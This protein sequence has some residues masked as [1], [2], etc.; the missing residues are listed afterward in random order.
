MAHILLI[1]DA[2]DCQLL[3]KEALAKTATVKFAGTIAEADFAIKNQ[4]FDLILLD[5][6]LP[7]GD[8]MAYFS[9]LSSRAGHAEVPVIFLTS[10]GEAASQVAAFSLGAD[11]YII[12]P[13]RPIEFRARIEA[14]IRRILRS[15]KDETLLIRGDI[16]IDLT[17]QRASVSSTFSGQPGQDLELTGREFKL[18]C[19][20]ARHE[21]T[22][23]SRSQ[24]IAAVWGSAVHVLDRTVDTHVYTL[25]KK[26]G[27][28]SNYIESVVGAG[29]RLTT[30][31]RAE[32]AAA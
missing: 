3:V 25:R 30:T 5:L 14:R 4:K 15:Q 27:A 9:A 17:T 28:H 2:K 8:G 10:Q 13:I 26:L 19:H 6:S 1:E 11:D 29:Y 21:G 16:Q 22:I 24:L 31:P 7:D 23:F 18:L 12:K 20:M 32:F